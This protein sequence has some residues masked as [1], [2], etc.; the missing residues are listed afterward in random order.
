M[1]TSSNDNSNRAP[2]SDLQHFAFDGAD[3]R[4][5][6]IDDAPW[7]VHND[8]CTCL[9]I[10]DAPQAAERLD[11][12]EKGWVL[13]PTPGGKQRIRVVNE[14]G[15]YTL[16]LRSKTAEAKRFKRWVTHEV[17]P[18]IRKTG[19][20]SVDPEPA[21]PHPP[22]PQ[23]YVEALRALIVEVE[24]REVAEA[25]VAVLEPPARAWSALADTSR[26]YDVGQ[27]AKILSRDPAIETGRQRLFATLV[28]LGLVF[29]EHEGKRKSYKPYQKHV[30]AGRLALRIGSRWQHPK[31][32]EWEAGAP[33]LRITAKGLEYLHEKLGGVGALELDEPVADDH[34]LAS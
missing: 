34:A 1:A 32:L 2:S 11:D 27:A 8:V 28:E 30:D 12:D 7:W 21:P 25:K 4:V 33:Q 13:L 18:A 29:V 26:D 20:Y 5:V 22:L 19:S 16:V 6:M 10:A 24:A 3:V 31:T 9:G 17:I 14:P 15:L 23:T